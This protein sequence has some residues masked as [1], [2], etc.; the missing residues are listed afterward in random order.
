MVGGS[1]QLEHILGCA[2]DDVSG[3]FEMRLDEEP[4]VLLLL[5]ISVFLP[6]ELHLVGR[7]FPLF[8]QTPSCGARWNIACRFSSYFLIFSCGKDDIIVLI[9]K[10]KVNYVICGF[11]SATFD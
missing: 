6:P 7:I 5:K 1:I 11:F 8:E 2:G 10:N 3:S 9:L 4:D